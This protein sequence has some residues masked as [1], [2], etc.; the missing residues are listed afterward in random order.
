M[1]KSLFY[2]LASLPFV[3]AVLIFAGCSDDETPG[4]LPPEI[5]F[6]TGAGFIDGS[7]E[8][9][10]AETFS[11]RLRTMAGDN[12]LA[13]LNVLEDGVR[14]D[15]NRI[16]SQSVEG[17]EF[18]PPQSRA[19]VPEAAKGSGV[20]ELTVTAQ[21]TMGTVVTY[22]FEIEDAA[23]NRDLVS[24]DITTF[25]D[26]GVSLVP[27][28]DYVSEDTELDAS[29]TSFTVRLAATRGTASLDELTV[30][31]EGV[32]IAADRIT[33][34]DVVADGNPYALLDV[35]KNGFELDVEIQIANPGT[36]N[37]TFQ[38]SDTDGN[39]V[40][41]SVAVGSGT[42]VTEING[43]L[44]NQAGE[45]GTGGVDLD[46]GDGTGS[47]DAAAELQDE[48]INENLPQDQNW[49][50]QISGANNAEV[51]TPDL[52]VLPENFSFDNV[53]T[54]EEIVNAFDTGLALTG[55]DSACN[56]TDNVSGEEVSEPVVAG[57]LFVVKR[58]DNYYLVR[59]DEVNEVFIAPDTPGNNDD[60]YELSIKF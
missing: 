40:E 52:N 33:I 14:I 12:D 41:V 8:L 28:A 37:Y 56:C 55:D 44:L 16:V 42:P 24:L 45:A 21:S 7:T 34:A 36:R 23:G 46:T 29:A 26:L 32:A 51:R 35:D 11:V 48:G 53:K 54:Q 25:G 20:W 5:E 30:L 10:A 38:V 59:V 19:G 2:K 50:R 58:D 17:I 57:D 15:A 43:V 60:N 31:E 47:N 27:G 18:N 39:A 4:N 13:A 3:V 9:A 49:R 1:Q 22:G 6:L